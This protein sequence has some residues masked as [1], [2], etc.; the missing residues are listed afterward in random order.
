MFLARP[1]LLLI[2][3]GI[4]MAFVGTVWSWQIGGFL[5]ILQHLAIGPEA[6]VNVNYR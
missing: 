2:S 6:A 1:S 4:S 3:Y 5:S